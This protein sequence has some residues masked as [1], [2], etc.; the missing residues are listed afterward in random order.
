[1][2][3]LPSGLLKLAGDVRW[4]PRSSWRKFSSFSMRAVLVLLLVWL[5]AA[6]GLSSGH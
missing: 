5:L 4:L 2:S 6:R 3:W 1:M